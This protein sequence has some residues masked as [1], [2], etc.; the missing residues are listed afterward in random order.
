MTAVSDQRRAVAALR[1]K[2]RNRP[3]V[4]VKE[5]QTPPPQ[6]PVKQG[7]WI[8]QSSFPAPKGS[9]LRD[10]LFDAVES[11]RTRDQILPLRTEI[12]CTKVDFE[13][14]GS[15]SSETPQLPGMAES[16]IFKNLSADVKN[17]TTILYVHGG[18]F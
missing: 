1:T 18:A 17:E 4:S 14:I 11:L 13:W 6:I 8:A 5:A 10:V 9:H 2:I 7:V 15:S 12:N 16:E 3:L